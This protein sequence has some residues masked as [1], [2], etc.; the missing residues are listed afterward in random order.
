M[1]TKEWPRDSYT[2]PGGGLYRGPGGGMYT[3]RGGGASSLRGGGLSTLSGGGLSRLRGGGLYTGRCPTPYHSNIPPRE[4]FLEYLRTHGY[5]AGVPYPERRMGS[6]DKSD[7]ADAQAR[8][9]LR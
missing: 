4:V 2:G 5:E 6:L 8:V 7:E 1:T 9:A 3:G